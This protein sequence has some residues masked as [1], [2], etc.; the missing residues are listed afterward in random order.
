MSDIALMLEEIRNKLDELDRKVERLNVFPIPQMAWNDNSFNRPA[1]LAEIEPIENFPH[2]ITE[3]EYKEDG[4][5]AKIEIIYYEVD[6]VFTTFDDK[7]VEYLN[8][9]YFGYDNLNLFNADCNIYLRDETI[10][11]DYHMVYE[12]CTS[13]FAEHKGE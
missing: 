3:D 2:Q 9:E 5:Y 12:G 10:H 7:L 11:V 6:G 13:Y 4:R 1:E 8:E